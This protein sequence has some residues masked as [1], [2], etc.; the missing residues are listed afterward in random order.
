M[1]FSLFEQLSE[2]HENTEREITR[3]E[4]KRSSSSLLHHAL[5]PSEDGF[6]NLKDKAAPEIYYSVSIATS[7][8]MFT[9][10]LNANWESMKTPLGRSGHRKRNSN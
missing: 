8:A 5:S 6:K 9:G 3:V 2:L 1:L 10:T 4:W 7:S